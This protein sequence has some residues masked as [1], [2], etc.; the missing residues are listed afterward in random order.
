MTMKRTESIVNILF[1]V[2]I[3]LFYPSIARE[4]CLDAQMAASIL[5]LILIIHSYIVFALFRFKDI[6]IKSCFFLI[7]NKIK[8]DFLNFLSKKNI[9]I[10]LT[11]I[12]AILLISC[13]LMYLHKENSKYLWKID[14]NTITY[15]QENSPIALFTFLG[16][17]EAL[18]SIS[19]KDVEIIIQGPGGN[20]IGSYIIIKTIENSGK[21]I[22]IS[23]PDNR[24]CESACFSLFL[25]QRNRK[26]GNNSW[27]MFHPTGGYDLPKA[28]PKSLR[29]LLA[30]YLKMIS[31]ALG[32]DAILGDPEFADKNFGAFLKRAGAY[33]V[34]WY[35]SSK[36]CMFTGKNLRDK[37]PGIFN[38]E[39][40]SISA[41][42]P[43]PEEYCIN[44]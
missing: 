38:L 23:V 29:D 8:C 1:L 11:S 34:K 21:E 13:L 20:V 9:C 32:W 19:S 25:S 43:K 31:Y 18:A 10:F 41:I 33:G 22:T 4:F 15:D 17:S 37:F 12:V 7:I 26:S 36:E 30:D 42:A 2:A 14:G 35:E 6:T 40:D 24:S 28:M 16:L 5:I 39:E 3:L 27:F 44:K